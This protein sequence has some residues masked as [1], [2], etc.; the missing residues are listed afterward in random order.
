VDESNDQVEWRRTHADHLGEDPH[1]GRE[2]AATQ[3]R[4]SFQD[5]KGRSEGPRQERPR[6][7]RKREDTKVRG[8]AV[9]ARLST[10]RRPVV[11]CAL[12]P[13]HNY[14]RSRDE[15]QHFKRSDR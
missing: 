11:V 8:H 5:F 3:H 6:I 12:R 15:P 7:K 13:G 1:E 10:L 4:R 14:G 2:R 9:G